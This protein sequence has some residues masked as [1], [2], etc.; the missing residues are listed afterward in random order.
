VSSPPVAARR[1]AHRPPDR[2]PRQR[3][4]A[5]HHAVEQ[6]QAEP[7]EVT[8]VDGDTRQLRGDEATEVEAVDAD[9]RDVLRHADPGAREPLEHPD[10]HDVVEDEDRVDL[11]EG[12]TTAEGRG[13][14][15]LVGVVRPRLRGLRPG[16]AVLREE[17]AVGEATPGGLGRGV[18]HRDGAPTGGGEVGDGLTDA[19]VEVDVDPGHGCRSRLPRRSGIVVVAGALVA[20]GDEGDGRERP[21]QGSVVGAVASDDRVDLPCEFGELRAFRVGEL[22]PS[23]GGGRPLA[24]G[25]TRSPDLGD[26]HGPSALGGL[27]HECRGEFRVVGVPQVVDDEAEGRRPP[28]DEV[29]CGP[30][31]PVVE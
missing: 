1:D 21:L 19:V 26:Q 13:D 4:R 31:R 24:R 12:V 28:A 5:G 25:A 18:D 15:A 22:R 20:E 2:R 16:Q 27:L 10:R 14:T 9:H 11:G 23:V 29:L 6:L 17:G 3:E 7:G 8:L 30:V